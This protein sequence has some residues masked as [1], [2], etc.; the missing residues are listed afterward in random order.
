MKETIQ[1]LEDLDRRVKKAFSI[2]DFDKE[3]K[4]AAILEAE[5]TKE[6]FWND[7]QKAGGTMQKIADIRKHIDTWKDIKNRTEDLLELSEIGRGF[8]ACNFCSTCYYW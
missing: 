5:S 7:S 2:L 6:G 8:Y 3:I 4:E 1:K